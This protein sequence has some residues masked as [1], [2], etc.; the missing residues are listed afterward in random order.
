M[1][2]DEAGDS[3]SLPPSVAE[4]DDEALQQ[5]QDDEDDVSLPPEVVEDGF[6][7][8]AQCCKRRNC[9]SLFDRAVL[10]TYQAEFSH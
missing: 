9:K 6:P 8:E 1:D 4:T 7:E 5:Q 2:D 10:E 3:V